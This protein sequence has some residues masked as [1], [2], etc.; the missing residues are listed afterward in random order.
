MLLLFYLD[1][2]AIR[3]SFRAF[4][5]YKRAWLY[6]CQDFYIRATLRA[7]RH[8]VALKNIALYEVNKLRIAICANRRLRKDRDDFRLILLFFRA[9]LFA[10]VLPQ[11]RSLLRPYPEESLDQSPDRAASHDRPR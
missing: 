9:A 2:L 6:A 1:C 7:K 5:K 8:R 3:Q 11:E 4:D 10:F